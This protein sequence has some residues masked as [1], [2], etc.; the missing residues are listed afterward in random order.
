MVAL[1]V[2]AKNQCL[3]RCISIFYSREQGQVK[4]SLNYVKPVIIQTMTEEVFDKELVKIALRAIELPECPRKR[5]LAIHRRIWLMQE[6]KKYTAEQ[7]SKQFNAKE[8]V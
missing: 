6:I 4:Q 3:E 8:A 5:T 7:L 2:C 1:V